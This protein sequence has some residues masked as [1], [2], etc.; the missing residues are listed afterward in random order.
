LNIGGGKNNKSV[1]GSS[2]VVVVVKSDGASSPPPSTTIPMDKVVTSIKNVETTSSSVSTGEEL[3]TVVE[4]I[5]IP[6]K[7]RKEPV[8]GRAWKDSQG[9]YIR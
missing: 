2:S 6:E 8:R 3:E 1:P 5:S 4:E 9:V 7:G